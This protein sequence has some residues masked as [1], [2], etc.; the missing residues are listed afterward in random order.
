[1]SKRL[2]AECSAFMKTLDPA[3]GVAGPEEVRL[4]RE[5][6]EWIDKIYEAE[7]ALFRAEHGTP[8]I[9]GAHGEY[10]WL[11]SVEGSQLCFVYVPNL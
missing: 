5:R 9:V 3:R 10:Q 8:G 11:T 6:S 1:M 4:L 7:H 2:E